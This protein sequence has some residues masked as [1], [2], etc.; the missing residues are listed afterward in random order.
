MQDSKMLLPDLAALR[1]ASLAQVG[2][3]AGGGGQGETRPN[4]YAFLEAIANN[5]DALVPVLMAIAP[6]TLKQRKEKLCVLLVDLFNTFP[7]NRVPVWVNRLARGALLYCGF[8]VNASPPGPQPYL[9][10]I[11]KCAKRLEQ[12]TPPAKVTNEEPPGDLKRKRNN[13]GG[14]SRGGGLPPRVL[15]L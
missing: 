12:N 9:Q 15:A 3:E 7:E 10:F 13:G 8:G 5:D 14:S 2:M 6:G 4:P 11:A 1:V